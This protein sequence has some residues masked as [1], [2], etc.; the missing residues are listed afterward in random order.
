[1]AKGADIIYIGPDTAPRVT[2]VLSQTERPR[3]LF[4][5]GR[6]RHYAVKAPD[7]GFRFVRVPTR[8]P[9]P[10]RGRA[11]H[12]ACRPCPTSADGIPQSAVRKH[13]YN[14]GHRPI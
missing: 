11:G 1:M 8:A 9:Q 6:P 4:L 10:R 2:Q 14:R 13:L 5:A 3:I 12:R 7:P